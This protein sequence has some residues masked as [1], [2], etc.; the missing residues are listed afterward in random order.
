MLA[1]DSSQVPR[2]TTASGRPRVVS[3]TGFVPMHV[4]VGRSRLT[5]VLG[6]KHDWRRLKV[7]R[8]GSEVKSGTAQG[9]AKTNSAVPRGAP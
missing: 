7:T 1:E 4:H 2:H 3:M 5:S 8:P 9:S 6:S